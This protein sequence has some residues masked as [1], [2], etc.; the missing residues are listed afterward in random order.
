MNLFEKILFFI[1]VPRCVSCGE[2]L[3]ISEHALCKKC[4]AQY[5]D[6]KERNCS[7]CS[8][9]LYYCACTSE[10]LDA[11]FIHE[12]IKVFRYK[13]GENSPANELIYKLKRENRRDLINFLASELTYSIR[14]SITVNEN[15][16][17][18]CV[19]RRRRAKS[20]YGIDHAEKLAKA[21]ARNFSA[22]YKS[23]LKSKAK[24]PQKK[25]DSR[26]KRIQNAKFKLKNDKLDL[27]GK[28]VII[29]DDIVTTGASLGA[30][31]FSIKPLTPKKIVGASIAI[32]YKDTYR[33]FSTNDR[34]NGRE[35]IL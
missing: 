27:S 12:H 21:V 11:H 33:Q 10:Y 31:A 22:E 6:Y 30:A 24:S 29:I 25:S 8:K 28:T 23:L 32:A 3:H 18:T 19:P 7:I 20:K 35:F 16:I 5:L 14:N 2:R 1:S 34:F 9:P 13:S 15:T 17:F 26:E 4:K